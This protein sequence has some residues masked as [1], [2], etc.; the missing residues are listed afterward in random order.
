[1]RSNIVILKAF[2]STSGRGWSGSVFIFIFTNPEVFIFNV[3]I[4]VAQLNFN[5]LQD[6]SGCQ[7]DVVHCGKLQTTFTLSFLIFCPAGPLGGNFDNNSVI[8]T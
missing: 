4:Q 1:M 2:A 6:G 5:S 8:F 3:Q 7:F